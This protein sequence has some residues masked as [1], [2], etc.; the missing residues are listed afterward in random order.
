MYFGTALQQHRCLHF[1]KMDEQWITQLISL[2]IDN[3]STFQSHSYLGHC[4]LNLLTLQCVGN[5]HWEL[6]NIWLKAKA[7]HSVNIPQSRE[8]AL[9]GRTPYKPPKEGSGRS[10]VC[11][12]ERAPIYTYSN[13]LPSNS[14]KYKTNNGAMVLGVASERGCISYAVLKLDICDP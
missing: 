8:R 13:P 1:Y 12:H 7:L 6:S 3:L 5:F 2:R 11:N 4:S 10:F 14:L 9:M